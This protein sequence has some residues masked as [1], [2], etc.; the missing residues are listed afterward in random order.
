MYLADNSIFLAVASILSVFE[1]SK[2]QDKAGKVVEPEV[3]FSGFIRYR[4]YLF[5]N[6]TTI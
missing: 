3:D 5:N 1:I 6:Y 2:K 4:F